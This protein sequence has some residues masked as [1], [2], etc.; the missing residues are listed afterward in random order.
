MTAIVKVVRFMQANKYQAYKTDT[1]FGESSKSI[2]IA[3]GAG[4][5]LS[6]LISVVLLFHINPFE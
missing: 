1:I 3:I 2:M 5:L 4:L 6:L